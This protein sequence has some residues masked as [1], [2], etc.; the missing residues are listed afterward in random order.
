MTYDY[1]I[2]GRFAVFDA[3]WDFVTDAFPSRESYSIYAQTTYSFTEDFRLVSG[4][5]YSE[6]TFSTNVSNFYN[7]DVFEASG[8]VDKSHWKGCR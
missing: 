4:V 5:R 7:V 8:D 1:G 3:E 2:P 6:D